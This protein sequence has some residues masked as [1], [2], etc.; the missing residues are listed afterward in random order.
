[1]SG[2]LAGRRAYVTG[3]S[4]GIGAAVVEAL[5]GAGAH[6]AIGASRHGAQAR[7]MAARLATAER[8]ISVVEADLLD[9][10][11][12]DKAAQTALATLGG[13]D[14]FVH[15]AGIDVSRTAPTHETEDDI[16]DRMIGLHLNAAFHLAKRLLPALIKGTRPSVTFVGS[17]AGLV[18]WEGDVAYNVAKAGL[19]HLARCIAADYAKQGLRANAVAPGVIDTPLTRGYAAGMEGGEAAGMKVLAGLHPI[20]RYATPAEVASAVLFLASD[21]ASFITGAVLPVDGGLVMV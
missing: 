5:A 7:A 11:A 17:V 9:R 20:G 13:L 10:A 14:I 21:Q 8:R 16:W 6:V 19:H 4:S 18:A 3:G 2:I 15:C 12:L 1:M